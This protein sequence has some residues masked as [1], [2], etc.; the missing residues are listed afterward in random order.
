MITLNE[1]RAAAAV[2]PAVAA[3]VAARDTTA[4]AASMPPRTVY[5]QALIGVGTVLTMMG[6][7]AGAAMLD[8]I[9]AASAQSSPLKWGLRLL[10]NGT[11]NVGSSATRD[12]FDALVAVGIMPQ[13]VCEG[14]KALGEQTV[15]VDEFE[16]RCVAFAD[17]GDWQL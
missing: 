4:I 3:A 15:P 11:L 6:S 17:N 1:I 14:L 10:L 2:S 7:D 9:E 13:A 5:V 8:A 16:V 12:K